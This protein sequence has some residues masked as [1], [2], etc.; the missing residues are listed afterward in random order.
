[1]RSPE[2]ILGIIGEIDN[3]LV[4]LDI[5]FREAEEKL[6]EFSTREPDSFALRGLGS[7]LHDFYTNIEDIF[8]MI[9]TDIDGSKISESQDWHKRL[10]V[11]MSIPIPE[12]RP[13][14]I[15]KDLYNKLDEYLRFR[16]VFRNVYGYL[17]EWKR[18]RPLLEDL[19]TTY[20]Q[21]KLEIGVFR[22]FLFDM[23]LRI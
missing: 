16:H 12:I 8:E 21:F 2:E 22:S 23:S 4:S 11:R 15:S 14:V 20:N 9:S 7:L 19:E 1:M 13:P 5:I 3:L 6:K 17:L 18:I 10:L